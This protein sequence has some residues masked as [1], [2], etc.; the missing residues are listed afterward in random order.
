[1]K[2]NALTR[3]GANKIQKQIEVLRKN[4]IQVSSSHENDLHIIFNPQIEKSLTTD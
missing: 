2:L 3:G 1:V 4:V